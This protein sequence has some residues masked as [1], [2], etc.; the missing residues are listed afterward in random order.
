MRCKPTRHRRG[1]PGQRQRKASRSAPHRAAEA[2]SYN[3]GKPPRLREASTAFAG[4]MSSVGV[5]T[6]GSPACTGRCIHSTNKG[7]TPKLREASR[8]RGREMSIAREGYPRELERVPR[9][10]QGS[11]LFQARSWGE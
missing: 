8:A 9:L 3:D 4:E 5:E 6:A 7:K 10:A 2:A 11:P 1:D